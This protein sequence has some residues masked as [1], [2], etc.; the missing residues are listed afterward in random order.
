M[1]EAFTLKD[2]YEKFVIWGG[3]KSFDRYNHNVLSID[4]IVD[5]DESKI[6]TSKNGIPINSPTQLLKED[7]NKTIVIISSRYWRDIIRDLDRLKIRCDVLLSDCIRPNPIVEKMT[8][9]RAYSLF[10]EDSIIQGISKRY[11]IP[12]HHYVDIGANHPIFG[13]ATYAFYCLGATGV[14]VEPNP[15]YT[16]LIKKIRPLDICIEA[17][18]SDDA[19]DGMEGK[20]YNFP[21][22]DCRSSFEEAVANEYIKTGFSNEELMVE[23]RSLNRICK[24]FVRHIDYISIDVESHEYN[25]LKDFDFTKHKVSFFNIEKGDDKVKCLMLENQY[26]LVS[27]TPSN[28]IF[29]LSGLVREKSIREMK[30]TL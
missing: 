29:T 6:G 16:A 27:E 22:A 17:G 12:I 8:F 21:D 5:S 28:W 18:V 24:E 3:G 25:V 11:R 14:C 7:P 10:S 19:C 20:F 30:E 23:M 15:K 9:T 13:N 2:K 1:I 26:E 4:Y